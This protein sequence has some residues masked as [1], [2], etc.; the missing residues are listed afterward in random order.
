MGANLEWTSDRGSSLR[1]DGFATCH[2]RARENAE[3]QVGLV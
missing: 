3:I 2:S 1:R